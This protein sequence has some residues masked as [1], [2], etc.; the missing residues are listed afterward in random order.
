M[1]L[2]RDQAWEY[3]LLALCVWREA[4][5]EVYSGKLGVAWSVR[6]RVMTPGKTWWGD[7][8]E[9]VI[10][11]P[12]QYSA[13][14]PGD[15][16][17]VKFPGDPKK[18]PAWLE[19]MQAAEDAYSGISADP[20]GGATHYYAVGTP[21]PAWAITAQFKAQLGNQLFYRAT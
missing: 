16:N 8:W 19:C 10:L 14:N 3:A 18:D 13:F 11:K 21:Q 1:L 9:E 12:W 15:P 17:A 20:T 6:N 7:D 4:R 5:G 2:N